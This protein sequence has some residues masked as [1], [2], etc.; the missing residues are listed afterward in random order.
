M[1]LVLYICSSTNASVRI[2]AFPAE[3]RESS[4]TC[5]CYL[6]TACPLN[7]P[8]LDERLSFISVSLRVRNVTQSSLT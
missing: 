4:L 1:S 6:C 7:T 8:D 2:D 5:A 3:P